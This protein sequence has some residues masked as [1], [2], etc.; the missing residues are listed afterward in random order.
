MIFKHNTSLVR[1]HKLYHKSYQGHL[2]IMKDVLLKKR[3]LFRMRKEKLLLLE[4]EEEKE[5]VTWKGVR[6]YNIYMQM[7]QKRK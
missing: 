4:V 6:E 3:A 2:G 5:N 1:V 7:L